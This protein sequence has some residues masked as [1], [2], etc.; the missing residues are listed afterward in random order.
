MPLPIAVLI[1]H[2]TVMKI[3][4]IPTSIKI[5]GRVGRRCDWPP[6]WTTRYTS[7]QSFEHMR[8][9][10]KFFLKNLSA[11]AVTDVLAFHH[12]NDDFRHIGGMIRDAFQITRNLDNIQSPLNIRLVL[13]HI[14]DQFPNDLVV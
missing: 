9:L 14:I 2:K 10:R 8:R 12:V 11:A 5:I 6:S 13:Q 7:F 4:T 1:H 3:G